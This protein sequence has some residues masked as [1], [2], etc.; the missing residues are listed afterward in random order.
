MLRDAHKWLFVSPSEKSFL[1]VLRIIQ[2]LVDVDDEEVAA[3]AVDAYTI[4]TSEGGTIYLLAFP[5]E[6]LT[7]AKLLQRLQAVNELPP[8]LGS[9]DWI[10]RVEHAN[11]IT[12]TCPPQELAAMLS[13]L[14]KL[15]SAEVEINAMATYHAENSSD[16]SDEIF[17]ALGV[18]GLS[19]LHEETGFELFDKPEERA[20]PYYAPFSDN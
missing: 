17:K 1:T 15:V 2:P 13:W 16:L 3:E 7:P 12:P 19:A 6:L 14:S 8:D 18:A 10:E 5:K 4:E 9:A 20:H 11:V